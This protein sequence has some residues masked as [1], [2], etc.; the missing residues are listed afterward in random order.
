VFP[1]VYHLL[2]KTGW[3]TVVVNGMRQY[4]IFPDGNFHRDA[5]VPFTKLVSDPFLWT[6]L[7]MF[8][9]LRRGTNSKT[10]H[11]LSF[12]FL[13]NTRKVTV[14]ASGADLLRINTLRANKT[15]F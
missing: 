5:L 15:A 2:G 8:S 4:N 11:Y 1:V 3:S 6:W 14:K 13:F 9:F 12:F 10:K 7:E